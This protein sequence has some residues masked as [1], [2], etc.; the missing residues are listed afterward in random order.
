MILD[1]DCLDA[2]VRN[3]EPRYGAGRFDGSGRFDAS[4]SLA[5]ISKFLTGGSRRAFWAGLIDVQPAKER[6]FLG[7][8]G[9]EWSMLLSGILVCMLLIVFMV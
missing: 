5:M 9:P 4:G 2:S 3:H 1:T 8:D 6:R 7:F